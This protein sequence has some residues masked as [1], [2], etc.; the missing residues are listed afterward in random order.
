[1]SR[2]FLFFID[3]CYHQQYEVGKKIVA[4]IFVDINFSFFRKKFIELSGEAK[5]L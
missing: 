5:V 2:G 3:F 4:N 1:L